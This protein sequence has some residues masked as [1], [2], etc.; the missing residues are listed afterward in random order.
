MQSLALII[1]QGRKGNESTPPSGGIME[2]HG[3]EFRFLEYITLFSIN[4]DREDLK[5]IFNNNV[6]NSS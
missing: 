3:V 1:P 6:A 4:K 5:D 2:T